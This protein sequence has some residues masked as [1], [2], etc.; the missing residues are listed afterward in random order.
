VL[1]ATINFVYCLRILRSKVVIEVHK[2]VDLLLFLYTDLCTSLCT[3]CATQ[4]SKR[5]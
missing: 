2:F 5:L 4:I 1:T 3:M